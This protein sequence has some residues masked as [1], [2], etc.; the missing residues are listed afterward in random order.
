L[1]LIYITFDGFE[2]DD[3]LEPHETL[4]DGS[5]KYIS[6][7]RNGLIFKYYHDDEILEMCKDKRIIHQ[8]RNKNGERAL[9]LQK[10]Y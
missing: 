1:G 2:E 8:Q 5:Y 10:A 3:E 4:D 6:E 9:V 7:L